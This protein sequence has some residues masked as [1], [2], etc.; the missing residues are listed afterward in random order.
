MTC[1]DVRLSLG[2]YVLGALDPA[3]RSLVQAH[4]DGCP[5][6]RDEL[7]ELAG[8]PGLMA[9][10]TRDE[11]EAGAPQPSAAL[12]DGLL[13]AVATESARERSRATHRRWL[14]AAAAVAVLAGG[15]TAAAI[16]MRQDAPRGLV[17]VS[18]ADPR[19]HVAADVRLQPKAWGTEIALRLSGVPAEERCTLVAVARDGRREDAGWWRA[20][21]SGTERVTGAVSLPVADLSRLDVMTSEG[22]RL[23]SLRVPASATASAGNANPVH[24]ATS[25]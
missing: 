25:W 1:T 5:A 24:A 4:L 19:T 9:H 17:A 12:L 14:A 3:E 11:V 22:A 21:Y 13:A 16:T 7:A 15:G 8:L 2:A 6:C 10:L 18:G 20:T 23:L